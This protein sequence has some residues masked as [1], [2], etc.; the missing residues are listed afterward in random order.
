MLDKAQDARSLARTLLSGDIGL[1][2]AA[3]AIAQPGHI[4]EA[5]DGFETMPALIDVEP[6]LDGPN[7]ESVRT[8]LKT[9]GAKTWPRMPQ[10]AKADWINGMML[11]MSDLPLRVLVSA[12]REA[13][14]RTYSFE[15]QVEVVIR[16]IAAK[17]ID[18]N[19]RALRRLK[20]RMVEIERAANPPV[21]QI[22]D[23]NA[24]PEMS[25]DH[26]AAI[27]RGPCGA[28]LIGMGLS[29][30]WLTPEI[31]EQARAQIG[32]VEIPPTDATS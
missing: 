11:G 13:V 7:A 21:A 16:E 9:I 29:A 23:Q 25:I 6:N 15:N 22:E 14:H 12:A 19:A 3:L 31:V 24:S 27:M 28:T 4:V 2:T 26:V 1:G 32:M 30:G 20:Q 5:I 17:Q 10:S 18:R 8:S